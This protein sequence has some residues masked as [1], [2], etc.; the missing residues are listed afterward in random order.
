MFFMKMPSYLVGH[1][2]SYRRRKRMKLGYNF[3]I[4]YN[5]ILILI[6]QIFYMNLIFKKIAILK[7]YC[8]PNST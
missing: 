5:Y 6:E 4:M 3:N 2:F 8:F 7:Y 1:G